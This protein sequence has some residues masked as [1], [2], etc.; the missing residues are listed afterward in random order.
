MRVIHQTPLRVRLKSEYID[1]TLNKTFFLEKIRALEIV[2]NAS[3]NIKNS[4]CT[5]VFNSKATQKDIDTI[6]AID[7]DAYKETKV[8]EDKQLSKNGIVR[9]ASSLAISS[10]IPKRAGKVVTTVAVSPLLLEGAKDLVTEGVNSTVLESLAVGISLYRGDL[11]AANS[12]NLLLELGEY[13][14]HSVEQKSDE[15]LKELIKPDVEKVW[16][17]KDLVEVE[18]PFNS[19]KVGDLVVVN[20]GDVIPVDGHITEGVCVINSA[21]MTG[22]SLGQKKQRGDRVLSGTVLEEGRVKIWAESVGAETA[23]ARVSE[24]IENSLKEK[25]KTQE[26]ANSLAD[27][28]VPVTL[29]LAGFSYLAT[30][31][32]ERVASVLQADYS[33]ALKLATPVAFKSSISKLGKEGVMVKGASILEN[34]SEVDTFVFDKTGTLTKGDLEVSDVISF[35]DDWSEEKILN[36]AA[37][38][39][40]HYFHPVAQAVVDAARKKEFVHIHHDE[41]EFI[42]AHGVATEVDG[43]RVVIGSRHFLE[44]DEKIDF[45]GH[46]EKITQ[47]EREGKIL[48]FIGFDKQ[49][50]GMITLNDEVRE[51]AKE[52]IRDLKSLGVENIVMLTGDNE[53]RALEIAKEVGIDEV[54][55]DLKPIE[56]AEIVQELVDAGKKLCFVG[57]GINDAPALMKAHVGISMAKGADIAK[58]SADIS[59]L[60][61]D[62][63]ELVSAKRIANR[64]MELVETN[65]KITVGANSA[66]LLGATLG[67]LSPVMTSLLHNGTTVGLLLNAIRGVK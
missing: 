17:L 51:N 6:L 28:L 33:C 23:T 44:D 53:D 37:S 27:K 10:L 50:L 48:L 35:C 47:K 55:C 19:L 20:A 62:I 7:I 40:E 13:I 43:K 52:T 26:R 63:K 64:T 41:V 15:L 56:K 61:D 22:E 39:E 18:V 2:K 30:K 24:Y 34:L 21:S 5:V 54:Y 59:L 31:D 57:D 16:I 60:R 25:S 36:L 14:E 32:L 29:S 12:T 4:S 8:Y 1:E 11:I 58:A 67:K 9:S 38:A 46:K 42:V 49:L 65:Y 66:I 45:N 3:V